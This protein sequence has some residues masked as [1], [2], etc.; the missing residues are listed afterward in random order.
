VASVEPGRRV[1][2]ALGVDVVRGARSPHRL[3]VGGLRRH[4]EE[5]EHD[6]S[7]CLESFESPHATRLGCSV[8][9]DNPIE[10]TSMPLP[11]KD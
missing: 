8:D 10:S 7:T 11:P 3:G 5:R 2:A 9:A 1:V 4:R 6:R